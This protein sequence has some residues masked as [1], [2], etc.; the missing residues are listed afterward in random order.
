MKEAGVDISRQ[1]SS[2]I[3]ELDQIRFDCVF[4]VC[5]DAHESCP[6]FPQPTPVIHVGFD[7]PPRLAASDKHTGLKFPNNKRRI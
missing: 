3:S 1:E 6:L 7:D 5:G 2:L 4:T